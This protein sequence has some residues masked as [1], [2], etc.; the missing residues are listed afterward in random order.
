M[1]EIST[2]LLRDDIGAYYY[3]DNRATPPRIKVETIYHDEH[4]NVTSTHVRCGHVGKTTGRTPFYLLM[5]RRGSSGSTDML[6]PDTAQYRTRV[7]A[8][9]WDGTHDYH[10]LAEATLSDKVGW[11]EAS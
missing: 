1:N 5:T 2:G 3:F 6:T 10:T 7:L 11:H 4:G 9:K 8:V